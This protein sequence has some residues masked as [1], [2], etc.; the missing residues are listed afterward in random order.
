[1]IRHFSHI[2]LADADTFISG[3]PASVRFFRTAHPSVTEANTEVPA[4]KG[5]LYTDGARALPGPV[6]INDVFAWENAARSRA[7][8]GSVGKPAS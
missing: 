2:F 4:A 5:D 7:A 3:D 6:D 8:D 1:M